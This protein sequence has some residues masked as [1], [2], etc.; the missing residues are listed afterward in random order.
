MPLI[1]GI[2][3]I[4]YTDLENSPRDSITWKKAGYE[5]CFP[6]SVKKKLKIHILV[7]MII[8]TWMISGRICKKLLTVAASGQGEVDFYFSYYKLM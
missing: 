7:Y 1:K 4:V 3:S 8:Y 2:K 6:I 5:I